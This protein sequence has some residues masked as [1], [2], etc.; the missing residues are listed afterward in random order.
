MGEPKDEEQR[1]L[2]ERYVDAFERYDMDSLT[3]LLQEDAIEHG[4][5]EDSD[6]RDLLVTAVRDVSIELA[7]ANCRATVAS[8]ESR[9]WTVFR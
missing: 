6:I 7:P 4:D 1:A 2:L 5:Y 3:S 9:R 8:L